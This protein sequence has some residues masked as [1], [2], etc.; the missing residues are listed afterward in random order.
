[1]QQFLKSAIPPNRHPQ[2]RQEL[3]NQHAEEASFEGG[4]EAGPGGGQAGH[5]EGCAGNEGY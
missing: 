5:D 2:R 4:R 1:M 3:A